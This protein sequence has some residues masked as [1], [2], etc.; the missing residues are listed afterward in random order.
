VFSFV[1]Q[2]WWPFVVLLVSVVFI[3]V[4]ISY[5]R[6]HAFLALL[7]AALVAGMLA[8]RP[9]WDVL[10]KGDPVG[11][12]VKVNSH[13]HWVGVIEGISKGLGD[14][15]RDIAISIAFASIIG[16]CLM[17][18][19]AA[20]K[21][22]RRFL[23][24]F[25]EKRAGWAV[26]WST[27]VLSIPIFFDTMFMLMIPLAIAL[28]M[29]TGKDYV[30]YIL[31]ICCG[32]VITHS[33]TIPHPGPLAMVESLKIDVGISLAAGLVGGLIPAVI[34]YYASVILNRWLPVPV[35][36]VSEGEVELAKPESELP[37]F[38][39]SIAPVI[40]PIVLIAFSSLFRV[41]ADGALPPKPAVAV[42][43]P[44]DVTAAT[45]DGRIGWCFLAYKLFGGDAYF[46]SVRGTVDFFGHKNIALLIGA[47]ISVYV[48]AKQRGFGKEKLEQLIGPP[49]ET[50]G[51]IILITSAGGAFGGML[52]VAGVGDAVKWAAAGQ[53]INMVLLSYLVSVVIRIAQGSATVAMLTTSAM[54]AQII[55]PSIADGTLGF[56]PLYIYLAIG[57][58]AMG[59]SWMNDSGFW[60]I[61][62][63][64]GMTQKETLL[65]WSLLSICL[66]VS[67]VITTFIAS[68]LL[69]LV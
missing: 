14:T 52:R 15:A 10:A 53:E 37:S 21:V 57:W 25:G 32:G 17:E 61:S 41:I 23:R 55:E 47:A 34:G 18:S 29:R 67:G 60:V 26:L 66:S 24:I 2:P 8:Y 46:A 16:M 12:T 11:S 68:K 27:Y 50:A 65:S 48:L 13:P 5:W 64:S 45:T 43:S 42:V 3:I 22:V 49:L 38:L 56:H 31:C 58:G 39:W 33:L 35:R 54:M 62:R 30:L 1:A 51:M 20:D 69:P 4:A 9:S 44:S 63:L 19:G 6:L 36:T 28:R 59:F 40:L 7:L